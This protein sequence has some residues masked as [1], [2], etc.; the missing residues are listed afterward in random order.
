[1]DGEPT[2]L[3]V[4]SLIGI[5]LFSFHI[6]GDIVRGFS[7][8]GLENLVGILILVI[9]LC[10]PLLLVPRKSGLIV[11]VL[12]S[13]ASL[14]MPIIHM[15]GDGV[16]PMVDSPGAFVYI[17]ILYALGVV[18][19]FGLILSVR[20]FRSRRALIVLLASSAATSCTTDRSL[21]D[22]TD[23]AVIMA[24]AAAGRSSG[25]RDDAVGRAITRSFRFV[26]YL[27]S[28]HAAELSSRWNRPQLSQSYLLRDESFVGGTFAAETARLLR[29]SQRAN[30]EYISAV[31]NY[32]EVLR[33]YL[34]ASDL[35][36]DQQDAL[37]SEFADTV[38]AAHRNWLDYLEKAD[39]MMDAVASLYE[40]AA[41]YPDAFAAH[42]GGLEV[43]S[44]SALSRFNA[45]VE[46]VNRALESANAALQ[47]LGDEEMHRARA[48][49]MATTAVHPGG[50]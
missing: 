30:R 33:E 29:E 39:A 5:V 6:V 17:W 44:E 50:R 10:G 21:P 1:M 11:I 13:L 48:L 22:R 38:L 41:R 18:G 37:V 12:G 31:R 32:P 45:Q 46:T 26:L 40:H 47:R 8:G 7:G 9:W 19:A 3:V 36:A 24:A 23:Y 15:W 2:P 25:L 4:T 35:T 34:A 16:G 49:R 14:A 28:I 43:G 42:R 27:D 20:T